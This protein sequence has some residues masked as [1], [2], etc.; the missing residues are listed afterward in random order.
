MLDTWELGIKIIIIIIIRHKREA[1]NFE[2][3]HTLYISSHHHPTLH[4]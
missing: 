2:E 1:M 3:M 4:R